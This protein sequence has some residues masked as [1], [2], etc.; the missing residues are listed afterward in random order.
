IDIH[1]KRKDCIAISVPDTEHGDQPNLSGVSLREKVE[2]AVDIGGITI[3]THLQFEIDIFFNTVNI[4]RKRRTI[5]E[6]V[7]NGADAGQIHRADK[8]FH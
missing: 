5:G 8:Q 7:N 2:R 6:V 3:M 1:G 4:K